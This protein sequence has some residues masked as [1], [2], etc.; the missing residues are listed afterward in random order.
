MKGLLR[1]LFGYGKMVFSCKD[2]VKILNLLRKN[3]IE[4][5]TYFLAEEKMC[6]VYPSSLEKEI[7]RVFGNCEVE[8]CGSEGL[9]LSVRKRLR[10]GVVVGI[11]LSL[12]LFVFSGLFVWE[13]RIVGNQT[14][15]DDAVISLLA[16]KG[17]RVGSFLPFTSLDKIEN[18]FLADT[19]EVAWLNINMKGCIAVI[20]LI[21]RDAASPDEKENEPANLVATTDALITEIALSSGRAT[22]K[23]GEVVKK[24]QLL[25][26]G[27]LNG[28]HET[29]FV[30]ADGSVIGRATRVFTAEV[31]LETVK[32]IERERKKSRIS[33][34]FFGYSLNIFEDNNN[35]TSDCDI[36]YKETHLSLFGLLDLPIT[37]S[38][39]HRVFYDEETV[40]LTENE[41]KI[42]A[43]RLLYADITKAFHESELLSKKVETAFDGKSY[44]ITCHTVY[45][46]NIAESVPIL[47]E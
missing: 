17:F 23:R 42:L 27:V 37:V 19:E 11:L 5:D 35:L 25:A 15:D 39:E 40:F 12:S 18:G 41:A 16:E 10:P 2:S 29:Q 33:I 8:I 22:V 31:S 9:F 1:Y 14:V 34:N 6:V 7:R 43:T 3:R 13:I 4:F 28:A 46:G 30:K 20:S 21:E 38:E 44:K 47:L 45:L 24:G 26:S 32:K 36:I